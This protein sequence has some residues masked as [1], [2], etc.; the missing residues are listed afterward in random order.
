MPFKTMGRIIQGESIP[1]DLKGKETLTLYALG[2]VCPCAASQT[3]RY[4]YKVDDEMFRNLLF[5]EFQ[6]RGKM[7][8][9][10]KKP[11]EEKYD[12]L[13][14]EYCSVYQIESKDRDLIKLLIEQNINETLIELRADD[15]K[16][17]KYGG[18]EMACGKKKKGKKGK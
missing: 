17:K 7:P 4:L 6:K 18:L 10:I 2:F 11:K 14:N 3:S 1:E 15:K 9:W 5:C 12:E 13:I 8:R 16:T